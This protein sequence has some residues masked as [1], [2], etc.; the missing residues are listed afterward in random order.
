M[1]KIKPRQAV[2]ELTL[3]LMYLTRFKELG[4]ASLD[5]DQ[6]LAWKGYSFEIINKLADEDLIWQGSRHA[7]YV[8]LTDKGMLQARELLDRYN[9]SDW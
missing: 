7:K 1:D 8:M 2:N 5:P 3:L 4:R 6:E 9:I